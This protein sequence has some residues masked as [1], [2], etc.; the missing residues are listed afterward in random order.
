MTYNS[1]TNYCFEV[2]TKTGLNV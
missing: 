1:A 2:H